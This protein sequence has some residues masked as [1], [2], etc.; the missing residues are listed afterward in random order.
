MKKI[1]IALSLLIMATGCSVQK[2]V[3][4]DQVNTSIQ[5]D[6]KE[7]MA[8]RLK[9]ETQKDIRATKDTHT[10]ENCDTNFQ[11]PGSSIAG[12]KSWGDLLNGGSLDLE[13][14]AVKG[15]VRIDTASGKLKLILEE[16]PRIFPH[17]FNRTTTTHQT[18][19]E[20]IEEKQDLKTTQTK[21]DKQKSSSKSK[22][23]QK[24][25]ERTVP[26]WPVF[27]ILLAIVCIVVL[28]FFRKRFTCTRS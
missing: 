9:K 10:S 12:E 4:R 20:Q 24:D 14:A 26:W 27:F 1:F 5:N 23:V 16:K 7:E 2:K 25:I 19:N 13:N 28:F 22:E 18:I 15:S 11:T 3:T 6:S 21:E 8:S 17:S